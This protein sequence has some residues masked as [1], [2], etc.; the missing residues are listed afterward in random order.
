MCIVALALPHLTPQLQLT[1][2]ELEEQ[3]V[4]E[5]G[6]SESHT[7]S[8]SRQ[9]VIS[10]PGSLDQPGSFVLPGLCGHSCVMQG[11]S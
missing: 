2:N 8:Y 3:H 10:S 7:D 11:T 4:H 5:C 9:N 6:S 1:S